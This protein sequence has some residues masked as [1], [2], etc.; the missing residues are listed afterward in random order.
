MKVNDKLQA[1]A[2]LPPHKS[3]WCPP[4]EEEKGRSTQKKKCLVPIGRKVAG[5]IPESFIKIFQ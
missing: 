4:I 5:S 2:V 1:S 3:S